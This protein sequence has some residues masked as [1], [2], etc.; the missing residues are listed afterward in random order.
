M[1]A[2]AGFEPASRGVFVISEDPSFRDTS[3]A[4]HLTNHLQISSGSW[5][6]DDGAMSEYSVEEDLKV[7]T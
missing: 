1:V 2:P 4:S 7:S 3:K 6:L 5:P